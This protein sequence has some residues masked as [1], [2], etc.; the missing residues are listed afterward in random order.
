M[1]NI[2]VEFLP[3]WVE[4]NMQPAF[5]DKESGTCLQQTARMYDRVNMLVRMFNKLSRE[6]KTVVESYIE[7]FDELHD[8]VQDYF[9]NLDVQEEI[10]NKLDQMAEDGSLLEAL[11]IPNVIDV[12]RPCRDLTP[13]KFD[14]SDETESLQAIIDWAIENGGARIIM[15]VGTCEISSIV[16]T[17]NGPL[18]ITLEGQ[19]EATKLISTTSNNGKMFDIEVD[20]NTK[21][22][23]Y[24]TLTNFA[25]VRDTAQTNVT[26]IYMDHV[27]NQCVV[28]RLLVQGF[29][30]G[31]ECYKCWTVKIINNN[32]YHNNSYGVVMSSE[33]HN[34]LVM[35]NKISYNYDT[36]IKINSNYNL[37][38]DSNDIED[39]RGNGID[40]ASARSLCI[41]KNYIENN[42]LAD[43]STYYE[44]K[45]DNC[46]GIII[47]DNYINQNTVNTGVVLLPECINF[48]FENNTITGGD[49]GTKKVLYANGTT[50]QIQG[51][52]A[53][54]SCG[55][56]GSDTTPFNL[57]SS[58]A[59]VKYNTANQIVTKSNKA[60]FHTLLSNEGNVGIRTGTGGAIRFELTY[61]GDGNPLI[62][63]VTGT[64][65]SEQYK[66]I[67]KLLSDLTVKIRKNL[68]FGTLVTNAD[69]AENNSLYVATDKSLRF[70]DNDGTVHTI[71]MS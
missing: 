61:D 48:S 36:G 38:L 64:A 44:I 32:F 55:S 12:T 27:C 3:P 5:Y 8:Y 29:E 30:T 6:T 9:D 20:D 10:N 35:G 49:N 62:N 18:N 59:I 2:F 25:I 47:Q 68:A 37:I 24:L 17:G 57:G 46:L 7:Q 13:M 34:A 19:G 39:N 54:N 22:I 65:G 56:F 23:D 26:G 67:I 45:V 40:V 14:G 70:K 4:T 51:I 66:E 58:Q 31:L 50:S 60:I 71:T 33:C 53:N 43:G 28:D 41:T 42:G 63:R 21:Q 1:E 52:I 16:I 15:P 11:I 69:I